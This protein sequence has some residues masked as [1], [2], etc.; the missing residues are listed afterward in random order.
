MTARQDAMAMAI[1]RREY[2]RVA[3]YLALAI[4]RAARAAPPGTIDD[5]LALLARDGVEERDD[6]RD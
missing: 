5:V 6:R 2:E 3:L 1:R 4:A